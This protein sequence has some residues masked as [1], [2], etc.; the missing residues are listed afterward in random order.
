MLLFRRK[1][2]YKYHDI[3][4]TV[5][6][7]DDFGYHSECLK[8]ITVLKQKD[9]E[10]F[11]DFCKTQAIPSLPSGL[12]EQ[13]IPAVNCDLEE[14]R[15]TLNDQPTTLSVDE[16]LSTTALNEQPSTSAQEDDHSQCIQNLSSA[17]TISQQANSST[18]IN[19]KSACL[20]CDHVEKKVGKRRT[21]VTF[22]RS[23]ATVETIK[24]MAGK[25][26]DSK[27][28][29]KLESPQSIAYHSTCLSSYQISLKRKYE[30]HPEPGYWHKN[31]Q[32]HQLAFNAISEII[33]AEI[34]EKNRVMYLTDLLF[35]Y[36]S[37]LLEFAE[38]QVRAEDLQ[39]YRAENLENKIIKAFGDR[40]TVESSMGTPK[41]KIVYQYDMNT[42]RLVS[43]IAKLESNEKNR[44]RDV[45][46]ELRNCIT[47]VESTKLPDNLTPEDIILGECNI[48]EQ[49][50][51]FVCDL[52]QGPDTR[53]KNS[54]D[55]LV[56]IKS[57]C[58]DLI[59]I[60]SK[61]YNCKIGIDGGNVSHSAEGDSDMEAHAVRPSAP[62]AAETPR[63]VPLSAESEPKRRS[64]SFSAFER[65]SAMD[66]D[67]QTTKAPIRR[68]RSPEEDTE[69]KR[70]K[71]APQRDPRLARY[72]GAVEGR[73]Y[74][75]VVTSPPPTTT[76]IPAATATNAAHRSDI[77]A[78]ATSAATAATA[79]PQGEE[80]R[81]RYPP[82]IVELLPNWA[83]HMR[84]LKK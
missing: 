24:S 45:A 73:S 4:L 13:T 58:S 1:K 28:L 64:L 69:A 72:A 38:G 82:L 48:P 53:R 23:E 57:V 36:K 40:I 61:G 33:K 22:P 18:I 62:S 67:A 47:S 8:K 17:G 60:V 16:Q 49:L 15:A 5:E 56:K 21:Y 39:E 32:F 11:E 9:K 35:Q 81:R 2:K 30:E 52:V 78:A 25:S 84:E 59:Y 26:N 63:A 50:F 12:H 37:L 80:R 7:T 51:N 55:D 54:S 71:P 66:T 76:E 79:T 46:Y 31:R 74:A 44:C 68:P 19:K 70:Y 41:R 6:S 3:L 83:Q 77:T 43:E 27:L 65:P 34:I 42:S 20:F 10:E 14:S 75:R 29:A